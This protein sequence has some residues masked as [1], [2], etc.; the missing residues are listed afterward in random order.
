MQTP[1]YSILIVDDQPSI[2]KLLACVFSA[3]GFEVQTANDGAEALAICESST[4]DVL[5]TDVVMP[6]LSGHELV[7]WVQARYPEIQCVLMSGFDDGSDI[8][9]KSPSQTCEFLRKPFVPSEAVAMI[10]EVLERALC[11]LG[12]VS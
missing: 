3:A 7:R 8:F 2:T 5:L 6:G 1:G 12:M 11:P 9:E 4:F 10:A